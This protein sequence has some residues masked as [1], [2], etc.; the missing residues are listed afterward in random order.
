MNTT[1]NTAATPT[2]AVAAT[3]AVAPASAETSAAPVTVKAATPEDAR[4]TR[5][6]R[7]LDLL[8][9]AS[10]KQDRKNRAPWNDHAA[11][12]SRLVEEIGGYTKVWP[13]TINS[14]VYL[15]ADRAVKGK[16]FEAV[17]RAYVA[18]I[19][20][21][22]E[23]LAVEEKRVVAYV[24]LAFSASKKPAMAEIYVAHGLEVPMSVSAKFAEREKKDAEYVARK[25]ADQ[26]KI[27]FQRKVN[28][29]RH[30]RLHKGMTL[31]AKGQEM[32]ACGYTRVPG[33]SKPGVLY[34][35]GRDPE[36][37]E[38]VKKPIFG[39][40]PGVPGTKPSLPRGKSVVV[41]H[42]TPLSAMEKAHRD[43]ERDARR[44]ERSVNPNK[45][46]GKKK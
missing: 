34:F 30:P 3:P 16:I 24:S 1:D 39:E 26:A 8:V 28:A 36:T 2:P 45:G 35:E 25:A 32:L 43:S 41:R 19:F 9:Q 4:I 22:K 10:Y 31:L 14:F 23:R 27:E 21:D 46:A 20:G 17:T 12:F 6:N 15:C 42:R 33:A 37:G 44:I 38:L 18:E 29:F 40:G 11:N 5:L 7:E 13:G